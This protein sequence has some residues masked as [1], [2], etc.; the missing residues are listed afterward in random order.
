MNDLPRVSHERRPGAAGEWRRDPEA[1][2][3]AGVCAGVADA[4]GISVTLVRAVFVLLALPPFSGI[5]VVLY[6]VLWFLMPSDDGVSG[7]DRAVDTVARLAA[8]PPRRPRRS[9]PREE[10]SEDEAF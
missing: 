4:L 7:L 5:G 1:R 10:T 8:D 3:I 9:G 2:K 6:L